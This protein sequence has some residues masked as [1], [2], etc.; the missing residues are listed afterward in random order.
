M[1]YKTEGMKSNVVSLI[2]ELSESKALANMEKDNN[3]NNNDK[4]VYNDGKKLKEI[5]NEYSYEGNA[6]INYYK[7]SDN[8][9]DKK[10]TNNNDI[11]N[12]CDRNSN[13]I[14]KNDNDDNNNN[15]SNTNKNNK[16]AFINNN[17]N[18]DKD[19]NHNRSGDIEYSSVDPFAF[20]PD[21]SYTDDGFE[22]ESGNEIGITSDISYINASSRSNKNKSDDDNNSNNND[23]NDINNNDNNSNENND[24]NKTFICDY[25]DDDSDNLLMNTNN[26]SNRCEI[27]LPENNIGNNIQKSIKIRS[28]SASAAVTGA[29]DYDVK[30]LLAKLGIGVVEKK[31]K[32]PV[33]EFNRKNEIRVKNDNDDDYDNNNNNRSNTNNNNHEIYNSDINNV[34]KTMQFNHEGYSSS[35]DKNNKHNRNRKVKS[36]M[37]DWRNFFQTDIS[38]N[39]QNLSKNDKKTNCK[40]NPEIKR[41]DHIINKIR[42][43]NNMPNSDVKWTPERLLELME[44]KI[45]Y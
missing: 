11:H 5:S 24:I 19:N 31:R 43:K 33:M 2:K 22:S 1:S 3:D 38:P 45:I 35:S 44:N 21:Y 17:N 13:I 29:S 10:S 37:S 30:G 25:I 39:S 40:G 4:K 42:R 14:R 12:N 23:N 15:N 18:N 32:K 6:V 20:Q 16:N 27:I 7:K 34:K 41:I 28:K 36:S 8:N 26:D 9:Y